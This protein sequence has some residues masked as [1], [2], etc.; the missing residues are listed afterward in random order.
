MNRVT[1][2]E[3]VAQSA[4]RKQPTVSDSRFVVMLQSDEQGYTRNFRVGVDWKPIDFGYITDPVMFVLA[5][6][7]GYFEKIPTAEEMQETMSRI[8]EIALVPPD[9][10]RRTMHSAPIAYQP[11]TEVYMRETA[12]VRCVRGAQYTMRSVKGARVTLTAFQR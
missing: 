5:N 6:E 8:V 2:C 12:R 11:F 4:G 7:E 10:A 1:V 9:A 3:N